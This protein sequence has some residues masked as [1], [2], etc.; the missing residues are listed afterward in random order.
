MQ[1][2]TNNNTSQQ[3]TGESILFY[4]DFAS[5]SP[6]TQMKGGAI[7]SSLLGKM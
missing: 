3:S 5:I 4:G 7:D 1:N 6:D 2:T